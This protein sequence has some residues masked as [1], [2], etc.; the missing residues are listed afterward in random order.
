MLK[1]NFLRSEYDIKL[2]RMVASHMS[3]HPSRHCEQQSKKHFQV[4]FTY[5]SVSI[6]DLFGQGWGAPPS[7]KISFKMDM[8]TMSIVQR[9]LGNRSTHEETR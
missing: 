3:W 1:E 5:T 2:N 9:W 7:A 6:E 4:F 8:N